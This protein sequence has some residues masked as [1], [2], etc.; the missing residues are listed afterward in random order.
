MT[1]KEDKWSLLD[2]QT[3]KSQEDTVYVVR[4]HT[5][6][7]IS[8]PSAVNLCLV[9]QNGSSILHRIDSVYYHKSPQEQMREICSV[10]SGDSG[11][12][13]SLFFSKPQKQAYTGQPILKER[14][15]E[16]SLDE[17]FFVGPE[18][19]DLAGVLVGP[20]SGAWQLNELQVTSSRSKKIHHFRCRERLGEGGISA[21]YLYPHS[22]NAMVYGEANSS[23]VFNNPKIQQMST[24]L[25][26]Q[27]QNKLDELDFDFFENR[28][29][30]AC[31]LLA[32][33]ACGVLNI[34]G[35]SEAA[36]VFGIY[37]IVGAAQCLILQQIPQHAVNDWI[38]M[39]L[40]LWTP[41]QSPDPNSNSS[42]WVT[43]E[44]RMNN[45]YFRGVLVAC[46]MK[47]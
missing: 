14:F 13:C 32:V 10:V 19:G 42:K 36:T 40:P 22:P 28:V 12:A 45:F 23:A 6:N 34:A 24:Q 5:G 43:K 46:I 2:Y 39:L 16:D 8:R 26:I 38:K 18:L 41:D 7:I 21:T 15:R 47:V 17:V 1:S 4:F 3:T 37:S 11:A 35:S 25:R 33:S 30:I 20:E 27:L 44:T 29:R 9:S 31:A